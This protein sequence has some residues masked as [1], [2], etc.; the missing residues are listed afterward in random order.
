VYQEPR[1]SADILFYMYDYTTR[2]SE[3]IDKVLLGNKVE[4][5][6]NYRSIYICRKISLLI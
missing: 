5:S 4:A 3:M 1:T 6:S 2:G